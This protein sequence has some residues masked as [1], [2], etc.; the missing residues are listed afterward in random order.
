MCHS[1]PNPKKSTSQKSMIIF[2]HFRKEWYTLW[3]FNIAIENCHLA[4]FPSYIRW[5]FSHQ[6]CNKLP[7]SMISASKKNIH[8]HMVKF[9]LNSWWNS[10]KSWWNS[11]KSRWNSHK[12]SWIFQKSSWHC[13]KS[14]WNFHK[15]SWHCR[16]SSWNFHK[17]SWH[18][19]KSWWISHFLGMSTSSLPRP[20]RPLRP[21]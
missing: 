4:S 13:R 6:L 2:V 16:K 20:W 7:E 8:F 18:F 11:H 17:S 1:F 15:S 19:H 10:Q 5:W 9:P 12:S 14:L 3:W 21:A